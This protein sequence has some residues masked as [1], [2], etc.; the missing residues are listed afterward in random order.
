MRLIVS[1]LFIDHKIVYT[2]T[3]AKDESIITQAAT[4]IVDNHQGQ[5]GGGISEQE[6]DLQTFQEIAAG[7]GFWG[8]FA[9]AYGVG[10]GSLF[11]GKCS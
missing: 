10:I 4:A 8:A 11:A 6:Y 5:V 3:L 2:A 9:G 1:Q 7:A